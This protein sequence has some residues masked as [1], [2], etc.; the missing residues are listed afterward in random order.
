MKA[1]VVTKYGNML[2]VVKLKECDRPVPSDQQVLVEVHAASINK[3]DLA[4]IRGAWIAR[5]L[6]TGL[7]KPK[8]ERLG[9]DLAGL[10]V[11]VGKDVTL[12][13]PGDRVF[14]NASGSYAEYVC[15]KPVYL[16]H[17]PANVS[18]EEAAAVPV[19]AT[20]AL[21]GLRAGKLQ[22]GQ[23]VLVYGASGGVGMF[24]VQIARALGAEVTAVTSPRNIENARSMGA[25]HVIDYTR[26]DFT[27]SGQKYD[28]IAAVNGY[29]TLQSY[30]SAL[31]PNGICLVIGGEIPQVI[32]TLL[33]ARLISRFD[34]R[35]I[36]FMGIASLNPADLALLK[37]LLEQG[38]LKPIIDRTYPLEQ[39]AEAMQYVEG[40]HAR[41]KVVITIAH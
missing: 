40:G 10:V 1:I 27:R 32:Q 39:A 41:A 29:R 4:P 16:A 28:L 37:D 15:A 5:L 24:A 36:N 9:S 17:M 25:A 6:G 3:S 21:Q 12:F 38:K 31:T 14:G 8:R 26:E 30:R 23:K 7:L 34:T 13:R 33:F 22:S 20:S 2:D 18:F 35:K 19:A 11:A